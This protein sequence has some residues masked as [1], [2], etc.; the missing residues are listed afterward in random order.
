MPA[1]ALAVLE[2]L[3]HHQVPITGRPGGGRRPVEGGR[4]AD[5]RPPRQ[6]GAEVTV[7]HSET[8]DVVARDAGGRDPG[9]APWASRDS[10]ARSTSTARAPWSSTAASTSPTDGVVGDVDFDAR[11]AHRGGHHPGSR[12]RRPG[13]HDHAPGPGGHRRGAPG[14]VSLPSLT[15][16]D[17]GPRHRAPAR[18]AAAGRRRPG[19]EH[20]GRRR[21]LRWRRDPAPRPGRPV[22][23]ARRDPDPDHRPAGG[24]RVARGPQPRRDALADRRLVRA[25]RDP[26]R[27]DR[28]L[29]VRR[30]PTR[31]ADP[32]HR[33]V[34]AGVGGLA[35]PPTAAVRRARPADLHRHRCRLRVR[36]GP[37]RLGRTDHGALLPGRRAA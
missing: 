27:A 9:R 18:G 28:R 30:R 21:R 32:A 14:G 15:D 3:R 22:R 36:L 6:P 7:A 37:G 20:P 29:P 2:I 10:S 34:P 8:R 35:P 4:S 16:A 23:A 33:R 26:G 12:W 31:R 17:G 5:L 11:A 24:Q 19:G 13:H 25:R 1:T